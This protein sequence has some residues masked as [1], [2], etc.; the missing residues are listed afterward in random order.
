MKLPSY[1]RHIITKLPPHHRMLPIA[2]GLHYSLMYKVVDFLRSD[3]SVT[4]YIR[5]TS[6]ATLQ[7]YSKQAIVKTCSSRCFYRH[8]CRTRRQ[9]EH[10][11]LV[12]I[13]VASSICISHFPCEAG[14]HKNHLLLSL[15]LLHNIQN[16]RVV[17]DSIVAY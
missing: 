9:E 7:E 16:R 8:L 3:G 2:R 11:I 14:I 15:A 6:Q 5:S 10:D 1:H 12:G 13:V 4:I 17:Q